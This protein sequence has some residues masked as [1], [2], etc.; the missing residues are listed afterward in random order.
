MKK[1]P[2]IIVVPTI[3]VV[4]VIIGAAVWKMRSTVPTS[5]SSPVSTEFP[6]P[7]DAQEEERPASFLG[8]FLKTQPTPTPAAKATSASDLS[9][10]LQSIDE[11]GQ[12]EFTALDQDIA[13]L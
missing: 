8:S 13:G 4:L 5:T 7:L 3:A 11:G 9:R 6:N 2:F 1:L 12:D 10:E